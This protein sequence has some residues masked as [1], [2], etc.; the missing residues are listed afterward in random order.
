LDAQVRRPSGFHKKSK[1]GKSA[2]L[3]GG[4]QLNNNIAAD[5]SDSDAD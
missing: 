4:G 1:E 2:S 3:G 5:D